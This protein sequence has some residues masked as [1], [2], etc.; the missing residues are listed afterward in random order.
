[1]S[2][3]TMM[4]GDVHAHMITLLTKSFLTTSESAFFNHGERE[5][6]PGKG[7]RSPDGPASDTCRQEVSREK[8]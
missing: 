2:F 8:T 6:V 1:M 5:K 4:Y 7:S 3:E